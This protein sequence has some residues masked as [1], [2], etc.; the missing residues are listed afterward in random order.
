MRAKV[1]HEGGYFVCRLA[2]P[3]LGVQGDSPPLYTILLYF[4]VEYACGSYLTIFFE[5]AGLVVTQRKLDE[6][7]SRHKVERHERVC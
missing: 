4:A 3:D 6:T 5:S 2:R 7:M 1:D